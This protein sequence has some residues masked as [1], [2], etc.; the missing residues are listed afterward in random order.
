MKMMAAALVS[1][2]ALAVHGAAFAQEPSLS[3]SP[4]SGPCGTV[5]EVT[6]AGFEPNAVLTVLATHGGGHHI[7]PQDNS[8]ADAAGAF[9]TTVQIPLDN[10]PSP[11][12]MIVFVCA[13]PFC[14]PKVSMPFTVI[15]SAPLTGS[16]GRAVAAPT[17]LWIASLASVGI[18][19]SLVGLGVRKAARR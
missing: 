11:Y 17:H 7:E 16:G 6:G 12:G 4:T 13:E 14:E 8:R 10:C 19:L 9:A 5:V 3:I 1:G 15:E 18:M 2:L